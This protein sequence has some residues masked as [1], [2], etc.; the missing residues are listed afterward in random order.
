M[1]RGSRRSLLAHKKSN[2]HF[3]TAVGGF[4]DL[5]QCFARFVFIFLGYRSGQVAHCTVGDLDGLLSSF[6]SLCFPHKGSHSQFKQFPTVFFLTLCWFHHKMRF[7]LFF[8]TLCRFL[9]KIGFYLFFVTP[10]RFP[11]KMRFYTPFYMKPPPHT[12]RPCLTQ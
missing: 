8:A 12:P 11:H 7:D 10:C 9:H 3:L 1:P 2:V 4:R 5:F 6:P